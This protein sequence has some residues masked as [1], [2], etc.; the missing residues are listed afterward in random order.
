MSRLILSIHGRRCDLTEYANIHPGGR[1]ILRALDANVDSTILFDRV[2]HSSYARGLLEELAGIP[3]S[4]TIRTQMKPDQIRRKLFTHEDSRH[5]HKIL[6]M[7]SC[8]HLLPRIVL[9]CLYGSDV[10]LDVVSPYIRS[11][12]V[13]LQW[14]LSLSSLQFHV[15]VSSS[16]HQPMIHQVF[17]AQSI[18]FAS[19]AA[20]C[21][22]CLLWWPPGVLSD[23][24]RAIILLLTMI[25]AD[26]VA[27][28]L[29]DPNDNYKTTRSM[30]Y[31]TGINPFRQSIHKYFYAYG[32]FG[33]TVVCLHSE[34]ELLVLSSLAAIQGAAFLMTLVR[35]SIIH[36]YTYHCVYTIL[37]LLPMLLSILSSSLWDTL[38][39]WYGIFLL[40]LFRVKGGVGKY[41]LWGT[42]ILCRS[43][44]LH[45]CHPP[46]FCLVVAVCVYGKWA[47]NTEVITMDPN[48]R[49]LTNV[50][51]GKT[52]CRMTIR[53]RDRLLA[54]KP[55]QFV[56]ISN[57]TRTGKYTPISIS[58]S[59]GRERQSVL[60]LAIRRY[61]RPP[62]TT[63]SDYLYHRSIQDILLVD[64][65]FGQQYFEPGTTTLHV[66]DSTVCLHPGSDTIV[67][68][69]GGSGITPMYSLAEAMLSSGLEILLITADTHE[70][71]ALL[72]TECTELATRHPER[73]HWHT[74]VSSVQTR[75]RST[76]VVQYVTNA[77]A[78]CACGPPGFLSFLQGS[79]PATTTLF[80]W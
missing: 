11:L 25:G 55:G 38:F 21:T 9:A 52:H 63:L 45:G 69:S 44:V 13:I 62:E 40:Y 59:P 78:V 80:L 14:S 60:D 51:T 16:I 48:S 75:L 76:D 31:W 7:L 20:V 61:T 54:F 68:F 53:T 35:K 5:L 74:H 64:G 37:L 67:L 41:L 22:L 6:G 3:G 33:A 23:L 18:L 73:L 28:R 49:V 12:L 30:P 34:G 66:N 39:S 71:T 50:Q 26:I 43:L 58:L 65:P 42:F 29:A 56:T 47:Q 4:S 2:G 8:T 79:L 46:T 17:R 10:F 19:R 15:P 24:F 70:E 32:Q 1:E 72:R 57:G 27:G 36:P 77:R